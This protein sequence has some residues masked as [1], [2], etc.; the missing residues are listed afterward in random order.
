MSR[1][2]IIFNDELG[3]IALGVAKAGY[4]IS[5]IFLDGRDWNSC[6]ICEMNWRKVVYPVDFGDFPAEM[7]ESVDLIA[8]K[9]NFS[10]RQSMTNSDNTKLLLSVVDESFYNLRPQNFLFHCNHI[11]KDNDEFRHFLQ[12][13][14]EM[15]YYV[16]Y[17]KLDVRLMTGYPVNEKSWFLYG[18]R[19]RN[20][21]SLRALDQNE[22]YAFYDLWDFL[23]PEYVGNDSYYNVN[24]KYLYYAERHSKKAVLCWSNGHYKETDR[25]SWNYVMIPLIAIGDKFRKM[26]HR[27]MARLKEIPNEYYLDSKNNAWLYKK[28][29]YCAN[30][31]LIIHIAESFDG[32]KKTISS[33]HREV[34]RT[35]EFERFIRRFFDEKGLKYVSKSAEYNIKSDFVFENGAS[36][37]QTA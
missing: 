27:E 29:I 1:N 12:S 35:T 36:F 4:N 7:L 26:T 21:I 5:G 8:G 14:K 3:T 11:S 32:E 37:A 16:E 28:L 34:V 17:R 31:R 24:P 23:E 13:L 30:V 18:A 22:S 25:I 9:I 19:D 20:I 6:R 10:D 33:N 15:G 2:A